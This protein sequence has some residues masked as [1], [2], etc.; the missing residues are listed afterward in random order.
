MELFFDLVYVFAFTQLSELLYQHLGWMGGAQTAVIFVALWWSWSY[1]AWATGW[2]DPD[3][4]PVVALLAVLMLA[5]LVMAASVLEG[6]THR[7]EAFAIAYVAMQLLRSGF[8]VWTFGSRETMGRNYAQLL[9]WSLISGVI[10]MLGGALHDQH[11][12]LLAWA[13]AALIDLVAPVVGFR[14]PGAAPTPM[15]D[16]SVA[17]GHL[18]ERCQL[19]LMIAFGESFLRIGE[20]WTHARGTLASDT[21]FVLGFLEVLA[22]WSAYFLH[23]A[24]PGARAIERAGEAAAHLARSAYLYAHAAMVGGVL[25]I[26]VAIHK[27]IETPSLQVGP[28]FAVICTGGPALFLVGLALSKRW[29]GHGRHRWLLVGVGALAL[30]GVATSF[31]AQLVQLIAVTAVAATLAVWAQLS[32]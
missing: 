31:S 20:S 9:G 3:R 15:S 6:F 18:A 14:L 5:S 1:T 29:L 23:H 27:A 28:S 24:E 11:A 16:W 25:V 32:D 22:L 21:A 19:L 30:V 4:M 7:G 2:I 10:W 8:M 26:A 17:G 12:R 13:V